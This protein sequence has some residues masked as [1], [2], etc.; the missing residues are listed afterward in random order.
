MKTK[1]YDIFISYR[2]SAS[3]SAQLIASSLKGAG[4]S[5]FIDV[6]SLS[7]GKFN[8]QLLGV[9]DSC[10]DFLLVLPP[11]A[12]DRCS[13]PEDWVRREVT[14]ALEKDKNIIPVMLSGFTWP[15]Q[16]PKGLETLGD[17]QGITA[18]SGEYF[19]LA[20]KRLHGY[21]KSR[22][23]KKL[24]KW[25]SAVA[26]AIAAVA[27]LAVVGV[28]LA[29]KL[30]TPFYAQTADA[31]CQQ[32][33]VLSLLGDVSEDL[34]EGWKDFHTAFS[35]ARGEHAR[36]EALD[37][38]AGK[39]DDNSE[40][41]GSYRAILS[42]Y[43]IELDERGILLLG[44]RDI[45]AE[46]VLAAHLLCD[47]Y[48]DDLQT[49]IELIR[50]V[51]SDGVVSVAENKAVSDQTDIFSHSSNIYYYGLLDI[52]SNM[53]EK[54]LSN[55]RKLVREWRHFPN[56]VGLNHSR[57]EYQQYIDWEVNAL[58]DL[59]VRIHQRN[60]DLEQKLLDSQQV[61]SSEVEKYDALYL[62]VREGAKVDSTKTPF[63]NWGDIL[64]L[65]SFIQDAVA[66]ASNPDAADLMR[67]PD[68]V[69]HDVESSLE[70]FA[71]AYPPLA[72]A[73][74]AAADFYQSYARGT[75][76][77]AGFVVAIS[78]NDDVKAGD[79]VT[80]VNGKSALP[81]NYD[82]VAE[83]MSKDAIRSLSL[84]RDGRTVKAELNNSQSGLSFLPLWIE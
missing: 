47:S 16:M 31:L 46:D 43:K 54:A 78:L 79:L 37:D 56:G 70:G 76:P 7:S 58:K 48:I 49:R 41:L 81:K 9:I 14:R 20:M 66:N 51:V 32:A 24:K 35:S 80:R 23:H 27:L 44:L 73:A 84:L 17:F 4:Y 64:M 30:S 68:D 19:D 34:G 38:L 77:E 62:Q 12:L 67:S 26:I 29:K 8:E 52:L 72:A 55:Y 40:E 6:E 33:G 57:E 59:G 65:A 71:R 63:E 5:V 75:A 36:K 28:E 11:G 53:P 18:S 1:H 50:E 25:L 60:L 74:D 83:L 13:D 3:D 15:D 61:L 22:S 21:L 82:H 10:K 2:R 42:N 69:A 45:D 39:L